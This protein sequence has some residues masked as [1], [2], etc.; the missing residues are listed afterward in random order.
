M[1]YTVKS[2]VT[3]AA[4]AVRGIGGYWV[5]RKVPVVNTSSVDT[6]AMQHSEGCCIIIC[7]IIMYYYIYTYYYFGAQWR[8]A[9]P[10]DP[11]FKNSSPGKQWIGE[12]WMGRGMGEGE[13]NGGWGRGPT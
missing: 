5:Y 8:L 9:V 12:W 1:I 3:H 4:A 2:R 11:R 7:I 6:F 10:L 13:G